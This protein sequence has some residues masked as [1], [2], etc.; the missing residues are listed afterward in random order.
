MAITKETVTK[1]VL[2]QFESQLS[3]FINEDFEKNP[4]SSELQRICDLSVEINRLI[5]KDV[6]LVSEGFIS[7]LVQ[8][9]NE[10]GLIDVEHIFEYLR[11]DKE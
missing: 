2:G 9:V 6:A 5:D 4:N 1:F 10:Q 11:E 7:N 3:N 8:E